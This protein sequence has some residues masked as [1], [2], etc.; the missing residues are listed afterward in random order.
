[1]N[2]LGFRI[3]VAQAVVHRDILS[4]AHA[5]CVPLGPSTT[6][7]WRP[8]KHRI[9]GGPLKT[10]ELL[11]L[12]IQLAD[13]L[14]ATH[15]KGIVH[16][17]IKPANIFVTERGE[18]KILDF[19]LAKLGPKEATRPSGPAWGFPRSTL[20]EETERPPTTGSNRRSTPG[21]TRTRS[22]SATPAS[23]VSTGR[24]ASNR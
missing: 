7:E 5:T 11:E 10:E 22:W 6:L 13:A 24:S 21:S 1:M 14:D 8:A 18:A 20:F 16:R 2:T 4:S 3:R 12:G 15:T 23:R 17:D 19:G 9:A